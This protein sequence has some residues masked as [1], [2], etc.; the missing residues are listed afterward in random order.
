MVEAV[1]AML[2][3]DGRLRPSVASCVAEGLAE[4]DQLRPFVAAVVFGTAV[5]PFAG[6]SPLAPEL[7]DQAVVCIPADA[8]DSYEIDLPDADSASG[9]TTTAAQ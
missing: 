8:F 9:T 5:D 6:E 2:Y 4:R 1:A 7:L 3:G